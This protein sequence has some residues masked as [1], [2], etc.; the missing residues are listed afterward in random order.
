MMAGMM[1]L[2]NTGHGAVSGWHRDGLLTG[3]EK[4]YMNQKDM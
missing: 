1:L 3:G 2:E 4:K